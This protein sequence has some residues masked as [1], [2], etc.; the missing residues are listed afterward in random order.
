M[1]GE[2]LH[3]AFWYTNALFLVEEYQCK[4][5]EAHVRLDARVLP[6]AR[7]AVPVQLA[8][9]ARIVRCAYSNETRHTRSSQKALF[10]ARTTDKRPAPDLEHLRTGGTSDVAPAWLHAPHG[11]WLDSRR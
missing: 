8:L 4:S 3:I 5:C 6:R 10:A 2:S 7:R 11:H 9:D 1:D